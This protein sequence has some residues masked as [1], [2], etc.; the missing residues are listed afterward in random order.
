MLFEEAYE[1]YKIYA[2]KRHKKESFNCI[3]SIFKAWI[4]PFFNNI[5]LSDISKNKVLSWTNEIVSYNFSNN[6]NRNC[7]YAFV[8]FLDYCV[9]YL[10]FPTNYLREIG[11]FNKKYEEKKSDFYSLFEFN[12]FIKCV[13]NYVYKQFFIFMFYTGCRPGETF[14]LQFKD[15]V[16]DYVC[17]S[18]TLTSHN[19]RFFDNPRTNSSF[20][21]IKI[22]RKLKSDILSLKNYTMVVMI[23]FIYLVVLNL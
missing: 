10:N 14:A 19:C 15:L 8:D 21:K 6:Y 11:K 20:R 9:S 16:G 5:I 22:D 3:T 7:Y 23:I 4:L 1:E 17:I 2:Q 12:K 18:K 13:D